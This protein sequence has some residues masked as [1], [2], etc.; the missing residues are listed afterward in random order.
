MFDPRREASAVRPWR[1]GAVSGKRKE[2]ER[3]LVNVTSGDPEFDGAAAGSNGEAWQEAERATGLTR[4]DLV[5]RAGG[6]LA[7]AP[8]FASF[9]TSPAAAARAVGAM[10]STT[11]G[12]T[13]G[14]SLLT[15]AI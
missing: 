7:A 8:L 3:R 6:V 9:L 12:A 15:I 11:R 14:G 10:R 4:R 13:A 1:R 2:R 5:V